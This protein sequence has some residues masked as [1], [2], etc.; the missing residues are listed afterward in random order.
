MLWSGGCC[1]PEKPK[2]QQ[3]AGALVKVMGAHNLSQGMPACQAGTCDV[4]DLKI[5]AGRVEIQ[6]LI[7]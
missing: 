2:W 6:G 1:P 3:P 5:C 4:P 7:A